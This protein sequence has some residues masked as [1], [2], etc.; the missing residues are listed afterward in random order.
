MVQSQ[1]SPTCRTR[2]TTI[3]TDCSTHTQTR[4]EATHRLNIAI[5]LTTLN[6]RAILISL[7]SRTM[8]MMRR[9]FPSPCSMRSKGKIDNKSMINHVVR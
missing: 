6:T 9:L 4:F 1:R 3:P 8:R 5:D 2:Q 7:S